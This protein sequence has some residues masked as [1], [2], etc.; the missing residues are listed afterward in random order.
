MAKDA[1]EI[2]EALKIEKA[3]IVGMSMVGS[4]EVLDRKSQTDSD[5]WSLVCCRIKSDLFSTDREE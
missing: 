1:S 5:Y 3:H 4:A 2:L